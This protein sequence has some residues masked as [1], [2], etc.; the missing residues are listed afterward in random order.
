MSAP[1]LI[2]PE[3]RSLRFHINARDRAALPQETGS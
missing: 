3:G 1:V 2:L